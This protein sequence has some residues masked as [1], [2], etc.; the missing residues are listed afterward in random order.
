M[1][2]YLR[3]ELSPSPGIRL[4]A[5]AG[6][7]ADGKKS[8]TLGLNGPPVSRR[9][10][11]GVG[12]PISFDPSAPI[13]APGQPNNTQSGRRHETTSH[14]GLMPGREVIPLCARAVSERSG[15]GGTGG[16]APRIP[17][18]GRPFGGCSG[19]VRPFPAEADPFPPYGRYASLSTAPSPRLTRIG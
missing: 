6:I 8:G 5:P 19:T 2:R 11:R 4:A 9:G 3:P 1:H 12:Q 16:R 7:N 18:H 13:Y 17:A 14:A 10:S 15:H